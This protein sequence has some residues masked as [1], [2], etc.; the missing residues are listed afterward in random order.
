[1][2]E[3]TLHRAKAS[4]QELGRAAVTHCQT[5]VPMVYRGPQPGPH[6]PLTQNSPHPIPLRPIWR[7]SARQIPED[8]HLTADLKKISA[9]GG[10]FVFDALVIKF[11]REVYI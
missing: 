6:L 4:L 2:G 5:L 8:L 9:V 10:K 3:G 11:R 7:R 1:M